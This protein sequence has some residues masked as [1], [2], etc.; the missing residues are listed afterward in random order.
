MKNLLY[1]LVDIILRKT[2]EGLLAYASL[3]EMGISPVEGNY[4]YPTAY[5][6][7]WESQYYDTVT[8]IKIVETAE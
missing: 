2:E 4:F 7:L 5:P 6:S 3:Y 1:K 8:Q